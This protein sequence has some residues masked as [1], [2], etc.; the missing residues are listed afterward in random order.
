MQECEVTNRLFLEEFK[1]VEVPLEALMM[2]KLTYLSLRNNKIKALPIAVGDMIA[3]REFHADN[4][5][6]VLVTPVMWQ[7]TA[8]TVMSFTN[9]KFRHLPPEIGLMDPTVLTTVNLTGCDNLESPPPEVVRRGV[10]YLIPYMAALFNSRVSGALDLS[11]WLLEGFPYQF[12]D[13][14]RE[15]ESVDI[16]SN[17]VSSLPDDMCVQFMSCTSFHADKNRLRHLPDKLGALQKLVKLHVTWNTLEDIPDSICDIHTLVELSLHHNEIG[18]LPENLGDMSSLRIINVNTNAIRHIPESFTRLHS[19][20][21]FDIHDNQI[22]ELPLNCSRLTSLTEINVSENRIDVLRDELG[23]CLS[24]TTIDSAHNP[25]VCV[26]VCVYVCMKC[27]S[28]CMCVCGMCVCV[29]VCM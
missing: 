16:S 11:K 28:L 17:F 2:T 8:L 19:L 9:N 14:V 13:N 7:L 29:Y 5:E 6:I 27:I 22:R 1:L 18:A 23:M 15:I 20:R 26:C 4:N 24:L 25:L 3:L 12:L 10:E 21:L